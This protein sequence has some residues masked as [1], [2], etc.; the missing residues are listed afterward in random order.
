MKIRLF[1][2]TPIM[3]LLVRFVYFLRKMFFWYLIT[4]WYWVYSASHTVNASWS[5]HD[6]L[7]GTYGRKRWRG[8][9]EWEYIEGRWKT[10]AKTHISLSF[11]WWQ[12][13]FRSSM[14]TEE[15]KWELCGGS[16]GIGESID[17]QKLLPGTPLWPCSL[18][19]LFFAIVESSIIEM[20]S[21]PP[22]PWLL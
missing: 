20:W 19:L 17:Y 10:L 6:C 9:K 14:R 3:R 13:F 16:W 5:R 1:C 15:Y 21:I 2:I 22:T 7:I 18:L 8:P 12:V 11:V 4:I